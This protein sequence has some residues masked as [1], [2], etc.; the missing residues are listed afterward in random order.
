[1][2]SN[3]PAKIVLVVCRCDQSSSC[4]PIGT[5]T[6][7]APPALL[8]A[9]RRARLPRGVPT[10]CARRDEVCLSRGSRQF[11]LYDPKRCVLKD[12]VHGHR[13]TAGRSAVLVGNGTE[14]RCAAGSLGG[15]G[16]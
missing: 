1:M 4:P 3:R 9:A 10:P 16:E 13:G 2:V 15:E 14:L 6:P 12:T 5:P 8:S 7:A 11:R